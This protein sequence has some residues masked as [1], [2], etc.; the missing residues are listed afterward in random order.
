MYAA[1]IANTLNAKTGKTLSPASVAR[2][3]SSISSWYGYL[4]DEDVIGAN[5]MAKVR[6]PDIDKDHTATVSLTSTE[7]TALRQAATMS[8]YLPASE[9]I[10]LA[11]FLVFIGARVSEICALDVKDLGH[12]SGHRTV[13]LRMKGGKERTRAIPSDLATALDVHL[14]GRAEGALFLGPR[15]G[16]RITRWEVATFVRHAAK[17]AGI[18]A[19]DQVTPHSF[20]HA[21]ATI[22]RQR[23]ATLEER[24]FALGHA[25]PRTTQRYDRARQS[26]DRD[27]SY[28]VAAATSGKPPAE[29]A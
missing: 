19:W 5:P 15:G 17:S 16:R 10:A 7:A 18:A 22:A 23:G 13:K 28:L 25:D 6:R 11:G 8:T 9:S 21:W 4:T 12:D 27:P 20:R 29:T 26:L 2:K 1:M 24:Q 14:D 3:L